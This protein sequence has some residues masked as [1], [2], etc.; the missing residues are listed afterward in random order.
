[1]QKIEINGKSYP[2]RMTM[3][4]LRRFKNETGKEINDIGT[5]ISLVGTLMWA[6]VSS[7]CKADGVVFDMDIDTF[8]DMVDLDKINEFARDISGKADEKKTTV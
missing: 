6:C 4:A 5:D 7:A 3:G 8:A 1:M 2:C